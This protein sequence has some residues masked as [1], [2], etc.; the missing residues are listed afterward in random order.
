MPGQLKDPVEGNILSIKFDINDADQCT[1]FLY[2]NTEDGSLLLKNTQLFK[3]KNSEGLLNI[4]CDNNGM[5]NKEI[6]LSDGIDN[7]PAAKACH[8]FSTTYTTPGT[9]YLP[10]VGELAYL[11]A[12]YYTINQTMCMINNTI[13]GSANSLVT[14]YQYSTSTRAAEYNVYKMHNAFG[15]TYPAGDFSGEFF[16]LPM[17]QF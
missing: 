16:L 15:S 10:T 5:K 4:L 2:D 3:Y 6:M 14:H 1:I 7:F 8:E 11:I 17:R 13:S 9:W 12:R